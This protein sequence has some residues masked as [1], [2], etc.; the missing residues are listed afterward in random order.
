MT[1]SQLSPYLD[2]LRSMRLV[3]ARAPVGAHK[4]SRSYKYSVSDGF[5][6]FWFRFV[7]PN[8]EG[9][10]NGL[11]PEDLWDVDVA[12][13]LPDFVSPSFEDLCVRYTRIRYG[14]EA[15][16]IGGWWGAA[17]NK[18]RRAKSRFTEEIDVVGA[19]RKNLK[20]V[21]ECKWTSGKML[22]TVLNDLLDFKIPAIQEEGNLKASGR[23]KILLF[24]KS[25]FD[26]A[27]TSRARDDENITL[28]DLAMLVKGLDGELL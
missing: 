23:Q 19:Q 27:L 24:S 11:Q 1:S 18:H 6:R 12:P 13:F 2:L 4:K 5:I 16:S 7:F 8:Q 9:L 17:Q 20:I 3:D 25:G 15:P 10:Q 28:I 21:G 26:E 14:V 22:V